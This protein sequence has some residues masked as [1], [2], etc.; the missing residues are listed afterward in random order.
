MTL[1]EAVKIMRGKPGTVLRLT[2]VREGVEQPLKID[3]KRDV[4]KVKS[5]KQRILDEGFGYIRISQFQSKTAD[6]MVNAIEKL[7]KEAEKY[8]LQS[9]KKPHLCWLGTMQV[10]SLRKPVIWVLK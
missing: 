10:Q 4:I 7:K 6:N 8:H 1:N 3:I 5:V 9:V 2:V